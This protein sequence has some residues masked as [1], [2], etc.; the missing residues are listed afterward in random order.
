MDAYPK[1]LRDITDADLVELV[2]ERECLEQCS[3]LE[4]E[5]IVRWLAARDMVEWLVAE[6]QCAAG[7]AGLGRGRGEWLPRASTPAAA[8][9]VFPGRPVGDPAFHSA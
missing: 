7:V 6:Q 1:T 9:A 8:S 5:L 2:A 3:G 4:R